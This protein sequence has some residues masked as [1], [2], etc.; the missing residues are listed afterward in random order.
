MNFALPLAGWRSRSYMPRP[1]PRLRR[2]GSVSGSPA[3]MGNGFFHSG[4]NKVAL[5]S[6]A[7][8]LVEVMEVPSAKAAEREHAECGVAP[9]PLGGRV[10]NSSQLGH[11]WRHGALL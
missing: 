9:A 1:A 8:D 6:R 10:Y 5:Q 11:R 2:L 3:F 7:A 4:R